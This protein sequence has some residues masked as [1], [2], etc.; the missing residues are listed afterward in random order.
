[1]CKNPIQGKAISKKYRMRQRSIILIYG[2]TIPVLKNIASFLND[3]S[4][5]DIGN[6]SLI[7]TPKH[8]GVKNLWLKQ[9]IYKI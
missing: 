1:M 4:L 3:L 7:H 5:P 2:S 6:S 8:W 9:Q